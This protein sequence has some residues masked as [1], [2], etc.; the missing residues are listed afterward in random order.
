MA[1]HYY[2]RIIS[3]PMSRPF[4]IVL[5]VCLFAADPGI[6]QEAN[7][8]GIYPIRAQDQAYR[9]EG[10]S[11]LIDRADTCQYVLFGEQHGVAGVAELVTYLHRQLND[12]GYQYLALE[13]DPWTVSRCAKLGV[14]PFTQK[15]P[16]AIA[17]DADGD[18]Q[19]MQ[20]A[21]DQN[22]DLES[23]VWGVDQM[24]TAIHPF[25]R[26]NEIAET[27]KQKRIARGA[28]LKA[29]LKMGRYTRQDHQDD[30]EV[31]DRVFSRNPSGE[32]DVILRELSQTME[33][34][35]TWMD[36]DSRQESVATREA[37]MKSNMDA[38]L[39]AASDAK[40]LIKM[41]GAHT[42]YGIG[43]NGVETLGEHVK[44]VAQKQRKSTLSVSLRRFTPE[45]RSVEEGDFGEHE[46]LLL[47]TGTALE[48]IQDQQ[49]SEE[50]SGFD[51]IVY[52]KDAGFASKSINRTNEKSF[53]KRFIRSLLPLGAGVLLLLSML[54]AMLFSFL[55]RKKRI[56]KHVLVGGLAA[57]PLLLVIAFQVLQILK[58]PAY[59]APIHDSAMPVVLFT[60]FGFISIVLLYRA[61]RELGLN[62]GSFFFK[63]YHLIFAAGYALTSYQLYYWNIGG[64]LG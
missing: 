47:E 5:F 26:I 49:V 39:G 8:S 45:T 13:T 28:Y 17:F 43:P 1:S 36:P 48:N 61:I 11:W 62:S 9:G 64:M 14:Y 33:I 55:F 6:T 15:N 44:Q 41:G 23:P 27:P 2:R 10:I 20:S 40:V 31:I 35:T 57:L 24:Q 50:L 25:H 37:L 53:K 16:H 12:K 29:V 18:L 21:I 34:F 19:L 42:M 54:I 46:I 38:Y 32:K 51:A 4:V 3:F 22:P 63:Y 60:G 56:R 52:F 59:A 7:P 30:L 58:Y